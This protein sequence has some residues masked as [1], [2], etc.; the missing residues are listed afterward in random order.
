MCSRIGISPRSRIGVSLLVGEDFVRD[1]V[2][3]DEFS[4]FAFLS[5][6]IPTRPDSVEVAVSKHALRFFL[7]VFKIGDRGAVL[8]PVDIVLKKM[9]LSVAMPALE[10]P[11]ALTVRKILLED[12][13]S[14]LVPGRKGSVAL[15]GDVVSLFGELT[16]RV[17]ELEDAVQLDL[18]EV[19]FGH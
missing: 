6:R 11:I 19:R 16:T 1:A 8:L 10:R 13:D 12:F 15:I 9:K 7:S 3:V 17:P 2:T 4:H 5:I 18:V 14:V